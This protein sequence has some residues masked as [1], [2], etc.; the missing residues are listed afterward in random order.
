[1]RLEILQVPGC[2]NVAVL[3]HRLE[4]ALVGQTIEVELVHRVI[5]DQQAVVAAG[6]VGSPTLLVDGR[7]PFAVPGQQ[8]SVSCRLFRN[9]EGAVEGAP[10]VAALRAA[11]GHAVRAAGD[12]P[13]SGTASPARTLFP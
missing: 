4:Q 7:D 8:P 12:G 13:L 2:P 9:N 6:M 1:V 10:S 3:E 5:D 11:L